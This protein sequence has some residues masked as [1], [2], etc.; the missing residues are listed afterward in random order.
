MWKGSLGGGRQER[1]GSGYLLPLDVF[2]NGL[3]TDLHSFKG[4]DGAHG[5][6]IVKDTSLPSRWAGLFIWPFSVSP[7]RRVRTGETG[8]LVRNPGSPDEQQKPREEQQKPREEGLPENGTRRMEPACS[9]SPHQPPSSSQN[10]LLTS[11]QRRNQASG[12]QKDWK[13]G[14]RVRGILS[15]EAKG[16][17]NG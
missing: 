10:A 16:T 12:N 4:F 3:G 1:G 8:E 2:R 11:S 7:R 17:G 9:F 6:D 5:N 15:P 14:N 13:T